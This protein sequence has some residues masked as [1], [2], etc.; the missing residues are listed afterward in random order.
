MIAPHLRVGLV[1]ASELPR[2]R[3][4]LLV[5]LMAAGPLLAPATQELRALPANAP[6][7]AVAEK[8]LLKF[9]RFLED[10]PHQTPTEQ[11][12]IKAM[13]KTWED[14]GA[15]SHAAGSAHT[16]AHDLLTV[17][18]ARS[19]PISAAAR[20]RILEQKNLKQLER[21]LKRASVATSLEEVLGSRA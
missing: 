7:R 12:F 9:Q 14:A 15:E 3:A 18:Q 2:T 10:Q 11:E 4:T 8:I 17:L 16:R 5:R 21:W 20:K 13:L 1:V 6:E 19:I